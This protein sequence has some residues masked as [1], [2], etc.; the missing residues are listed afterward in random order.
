MTLAEQ[1][2]LIERQL[3][4]RDE[5]PDDNA[6]DNLPSEDDLVSQLINDTSKWQKPTDG[7]FVQWSDYGNGYAISSPV[8]A[9]R[10]SAWNMGPLP[11]IGDLQRG[12]NPLNEV[13]PGRFVILPLQ[14]GSFKL[15]FIE[16]GKT[17]IEAMKSNYYLIVRDFD[18]AK[19]LAEEST[20]NRAM[21]RDDVI[22]SRAYDTE[23]L[24]QL[25]DWKKKYPQFANDTD[26]EIELYKKFKGLA[27]YP[28][29]ITDQAMNERPEYV[30]YSIQG[31][32]M[33]DLYKGDILAAPFSMAGEVLQIPQSVLMNGSNAIVNTVTGRPVD[34]GAQPK[35]TF[36][37]YTR[38]RGE[39]TGFDLTAQLDKVPA[40]GAIA[41]YT[42][43]QLNDPMNWVPGGIIFDT[44]KAKGLAN[45]A[46]MR[47]AQA[48]SEEMVL[49]QRGNPLSKGKRT[50]VTM[51]KNGPEVIELKGGDDFPE[52]KAGNKRVGDEYISLTPRVES[53]GDIVPRTRVGQWMSKAEYEQLI[54]TRKIPRTNVLTKGMDGYINQATKGDYYVEFDIDSS[55]LVPKNEAL[56]WSLIKSKNQM[57]IKLYQNK[58]LTLPDPIGTNI[59]HI[60]TK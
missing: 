24:A 38:V 23:Y 25:E 18:T 4:A 49:G 7:R 37:D 56:G 35:M 40:L 10:R 59:T 43:E 55:L 28:Q 21:G 22:R 46:S 26:S 27:P 6:A 36:R 53:A 54:K 16:N 30:P 12:E 50:L 14:D 44:L 57:Y 33:G 9:M 15:V 11:V 45:P 42:L 39:Q 32:W 3:A 41:N 29:S 20:M 52:F 47:Y 8:P 48:F 2:A 34:E 5:N 1:I 51:G 17:Y 13:D 19:T 58:G 31:T 60:Y